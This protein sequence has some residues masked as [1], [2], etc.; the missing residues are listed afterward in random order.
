MEAGN[1]RARR[2]TRLRSFTAITAA[3][4]ACLAVD[5]CL[6]LLALHVLT[7]WP[8]LSPPPMK[9]VGYN[10][11]RVY[12]GDFTGTTNRAYDPDQAERCLWRAYTTC[13]S[14]TLIANFQWLESS[15]TYAIT[16]LPKARRCVVA[17]TERSY[18]QGVIGTRI[19]GSVYQCAGLTQEPSGGL[20]IRDCGSH[21]NVELLPRPPQQV[22]HLCGMLRGDAHAVATMAPPG[23][24]TNVPNIEACFWQAYRN[25]AQPATLVYVHMT[26]STD[27]D[28]P[29][30]VTEHT[31]VVQP[32]GGTCALTDAVAVSS[33]V[34]PAVVTYTC[35]SLSRDADGSLV[36]RNCGKEHD[37]MIPS[38]ISAA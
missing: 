21:Y 29:P 14:S 24:Q 4:I 31:L 23:V 15:A 7:G 1:T 13:R 28:I 6:A 12:Q 38:A 19:I 3:I 37:V 26:T 33:S 30:S 35:A 10:C 22:G 8:T 17:I 18:G 25:C 27:T 36:A 34:S 11:G 32:S 9:V 5:A 20:L 2:R 16:I